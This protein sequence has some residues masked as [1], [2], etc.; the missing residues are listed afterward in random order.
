MSY[1]LGQ[2]VTDIG[3]IWVRFLAE[4]DR[5]V[6]AEVLLKKGQVE[7][8][9]SVRAMQQSTPTH[10][11]VEVGAAEPLPVGR[12]ESPVRVQ[13]PQLKHLCPLLVSKEQIQLSVL[14]QMGNASHPS[15]LLPVL[16]QVSPGQEA[17]HS[18]PGQVVDP[19]CC[20]MKISQF[21]ASIREKGV[22]WYLPLS[23]AS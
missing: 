13:Q 11:V 18:M 14:K 3:A 19:A 6:H 7:S 1:Q 17:R 23:A 12:V 20:R 5:R 4:R 21:S 15:H 10:L 9:R 8:E 22:T 16:V 2:P